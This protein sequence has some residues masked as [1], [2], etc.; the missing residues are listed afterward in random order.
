MKRPVIVG[1]QQCC[2]A[3]HPPR[4]NPTARLRSPTQQLCIERLELSEVQPVNFKSAYQEYPYEGDAEPRPSAICFIESTSVSRCKYFTLLYPSCLATRT[5]KGAPWSA[6]KS[7]PF[8]LYAR[9]V[10]A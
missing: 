8:K 1:A 7:F 6:G 10:C 2:A 4:R 3:P 9:N 5:R